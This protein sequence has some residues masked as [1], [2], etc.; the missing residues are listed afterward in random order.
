MK[1]LLCLSLLWIAMMCSK[2]VS[3]QEKKWVSG[4]LRDPRGNP[5]ASATIVE[6][7]TT[8]QSLS[9][10]EGA[11]RLEV[12]S[13][14]TLVISS[15]GFTPLETSVSGSSTFN[16][17][18]QPTAADLN[19]VVVTALGVK[20]QK[21]SLGYAVQ[22]VKGSTLLDAREPNLT[23]A[24]SGVVAGL[25]V[26]RSS[27]GPAGSSKINLRGNNSLT[28]SNQ[29][30]IVVDGV[31]IS[32]FIGATNN[33]FFNPGL[34]MGNGLAD[35][36]AADIESISVL[37]GGAAA[38]LYGNRAGGGVILITTKTGRKQNG[39]GIQVSSTVGVESIFTHPDRQ[40][41]FGQGS[42]GAYDPIGGGSWGPKITGQTVTNW[43]GQQEQ[44][45]SYDNLKNFYES[46]L[47]QNHNVSFQQQ[48]N[49]TSVY[50]SINYLNDKSMIPGT[51]L[52]RVNLVARAVSKF[53]KD[54][55]WTTDTK[56]QY[57]SANAKN[58]PVAGLNTSNYPALL[59]NMP[60]S[61]DVRQFDPPTN[62]FGNMIWYNSGNQ[63]NP[64]WNTR[65]NLNND[66]RDRFIMTGSLKYNFNSWLN[67]EVKGGADMYTTNF[68]SKVYGG[69]P[70]TP[71]GRFGVSKQ[72]FSEFNYSTLITAQKDNWIDKLG[73]AASVGGNLM[74]QKSST[75]GANAG[76][77]EV[78]NLFAIGNT[79]G[80]PTFTD[81]FSQKRINSVYGTLGLNWDG[82]L[83][84]DATFRNDWTSTL[85]PDN[86]SFF[87][88]SVSLAYVFTESIKGLPSWI[89]YGKL[90][91]SYAS[92][93]N[94]LA[95]Y[96]LYNTYTIGRDP[97]GNPTGSRKP[98]M[99]DPGVE[100]ELIKT[101][102]AGA[103]LRFVNNRFGVDFSWYKSNATNQLIRLPMDPAS[104]YTD[105]IINAGNIQNSGFEVMLDAR[106]LSNP[107]GFNWNI[108]AN[109]SRNRNVILEIYDRDS[110]NTYQLG[111]FDDVSVRA[112]KG[113][114]YGTIYGSK[115]MRVE[116]TKSP[117][118]GQLIVSGSGLPQ[119]GQQ[120]AKLGS[121]QPDALLGVTNTFGYKGFTLGVLVD[122]RFGGKIFSAT[123]VGMQRAGT[124]AI[125]AENDRANMVVP[126]VVAGAG[127]TYT[128]NAVSITRQQYWEAITNTGNIGITEANLYDAS[129]VRIRNIQL[130]YD[131][132]LKILAK[133]PIQRAKIGVSCNNVWLISSHMNGVDPESVFAT[134]TNAVGFE[135]VS[136]PTTRTILFNLSLT[137]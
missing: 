98:T 27:T 40:T 24:L 20:R 133:T 13:N 80:N 62:Q 71:S 115:F 1:K 73:V 131:L 48:F 79:K 112:T 72:T 90:R 69:S 46:G 14:A 83:Y 96:Q 34:D 15:I 39:L 136:P 25:Q 31:P 65:Y 101:Y 91:A 33:D 21:K 86:R 7:G 53:G 110:V 123:Q 122:A 102:E 81:E 30:L 127:G 3:A 4:I 63:I 126:G 119:R 47:T 87:Y 134:G 108:N 43:K 51:K 52:S 125:T 130:N 61:L 120:G 116:D 118:Y 2:D 95:P 97:N 23:N 92:V 135:N 19:E 56:I 105:R 8:N 35:I 32:N 128:A 84:L 117:Y 37:K 121:Q 104:G 74:Q 113:E 22:E 26:I 54:N 67:A 94:D 41:S 88:P 107:S 75:I 70:L 36:N 58:R 129:N 137:F 68:E 6:K 12:A 45:A 106:I 132:P 85:H 11:F 76:E 109:F 5:V 64:Y 57:S 100:N 114:L 99:F 49:N 10:G 124:A 50:T 9:D 60:V 28:G 77:L 93:G 38:A 59:Y 111:G 29:P 17:T 16:L 55:R 78:P 44:L 82:Y 18:L 89:S 66:I 42:N 103:E